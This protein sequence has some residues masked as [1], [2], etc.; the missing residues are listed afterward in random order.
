MAAARDQIL[1]SA[2]LRPAKQLGRRPILVQVARDEVG[3]F[4]TCYPGPVRTGAERED[5]FANVV[6]DEQFQL[7]DTRRVPV[8]AEDADRLRLGSV[9]ERE[10]ANPRKVP[11]SDELASVSRGQC[12]E[13][14]AGDGGG[15]K[16]G[17]GVLQE[18]VRL[19]D[20]HGGVK[21]PLDIGE[22]H[23]HDLW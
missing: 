14:K 21:A 11:P 16:D 4:Q 2:E 19:A 9:P 12:G 20:R 18:R 13:L 15:A 5:L 10:P 23:E 6:F 8:L 17:L 3:H 22:V 7:V 1:Q